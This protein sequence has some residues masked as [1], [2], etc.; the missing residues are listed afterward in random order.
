[1]YLSAGMIVW[2]CLLWSSKT[3][4]MW[5]GS[6]G[7]GSFTGGPDLWATSAAVRKLWSVLK[8][9]WWGCLVARELGY[10]LWSCCSHCVWGD[11]PDLWITTTA[12]LKLWT[13]G[14]LSLWHCVS[15]SCKIL[16]G[17]WLLTYMKLSGGLWSTFGLAR[18]SSLGEAVAVSAARFSVHI[19]SWFP[20]TKS[21]LHKGCSTSFYSWW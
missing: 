9:V 20:H 3:C 19:G 5:S 13:V 21:G 17:L 12:V 2:M 11:F 15:L 6:A 1:M 10:P 18:C 4:R 8:I 16:L 14:T 7:H